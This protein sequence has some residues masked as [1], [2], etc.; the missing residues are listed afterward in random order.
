MRRAA[1]TYTLGM[2]IKEENHFKYNLKY[3]FIDLFN[4]RVRSQSALSYPCVSAYAYVEHFS[5]GHKPCYDS[6]LLCFRLSFADL[7]Y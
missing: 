5:R 4:S 1:T 6:A 2:K 3:H 7:T